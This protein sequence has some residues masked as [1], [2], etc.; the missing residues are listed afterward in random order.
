MANSGDQ[1]SYLPTGIYKWS[2]SLE[3]EKK[4]LA[5]KKNP[6]ERKGRVIAQRDRQPA[7]TFL[8]QNIQHDGVGVGCFLVAGKDKSCEATSKLL[9]WPLLVF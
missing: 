1:L 4:A 6:E 3:R 8:M 9:F 5:R 7:N 2:N